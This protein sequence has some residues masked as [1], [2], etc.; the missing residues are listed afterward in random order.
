MIRISVDWQG[1]KGLENLIRYIQ[2]NF[3][4]GEAQETMVELADKTVDHMRTTISTS[5]KRHS[6]GNNLEK[7][8]DKE[9]LNTV[10][11]ID[12]GIGNIS[13]LKT[14]APYYE[15]LD[16]GG[17]V[18]YSTRKAAPPGS[19]EGDRADSS[20]I[21]GNQNWERSGGEGFYM[22]P[23]SP[24]EGLDYI[25]KAIRN[26]DNELK[27]AINKLGG[28]FFDGASKASRHGWGMGAGGAK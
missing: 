25:G 15:V 21:G 13:K 19:F 10:S 8:I 7:T 17:Y 16:A 9:I 11:G 26:L 12:I 6:F 4:Y 20:L 3:I 1:K 27:E 14:D 23:K 22:K 2:N 5:K 18:P 28:K 24:I